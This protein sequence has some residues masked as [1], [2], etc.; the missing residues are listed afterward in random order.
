MVI[1]FTC[2]DGAAVIYPHSQLVSFQ[3]RMYRITVNIEMLLLSFQLHNP[4]AVSIKLNG[5]YWTDRGLKYGYFLHIITECRTEE[6]AYAPTWCIA[7]EEWR[8]KNFQNGIFI[9]T[10]NAKWRR[11]QRWMLTTARKLIAR[12]KLALAMALHDRLGANCNMA[13]V[14]TDCIRL[15]ADML[16]GSA[17]SQTYSTPNQLQT[18]SALPYIYYPEENLLPSLD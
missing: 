1:S 3:G 15:I 10:I 18:R 13:I 11:L 4:P 2:P 9:D 17:L 14:R 8:D 16:S 12:R 6:Q 5:R 7:S